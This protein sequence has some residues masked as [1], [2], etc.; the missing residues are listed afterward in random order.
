MT[1]CW[2]QLASVLRTFLRQPRHLF[3]PPRK[4]MKERKPTLLPGGGAGLGGMKKSE[5]GNFRQLWVL[6]RQVQVPS[7]SPARSSLSTW[8]FQ[9][10]PELVSSCRDSLSGRRTSSHRSR[11]R[12]RQVPNYPGSGLGPLL[13]ALFLFPSAYF[14]LKANCLPR[15]FLTHLRQLAW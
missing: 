6:N 7:S 1:T 10:G 9:D 13:A 2:Q 4:R 8:G 15:L 5:Q 14:S 11:S 12:S 3:H